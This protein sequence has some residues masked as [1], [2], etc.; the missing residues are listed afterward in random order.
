MSGGFRKARPG[1]EEKA[2]ATI[3]LGDS[4]TSICRFNPPAS[5]FTA[6]VDF[7]DGYITQP[8]VFSGPELLV[9]HFYKTPGVFVTKNIVTDNEGKTSTVNGIV[10]VLEP[11]VYSIKEKM[12]KLFDAEAIAIIGSSVYDK[13]AQA[14]SYID[15]KNY[16]EARNSM[17]ALLSQLETKIDTSSDAA[18]ILISQVQYII[19]SFSMASVSNN[20][21]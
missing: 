5:S 6:S 18:A 2:Q 7:G 21:P 8:F 1:E 19:K 17:Q 20:I 16:I 10:M 9:E 12:A 11:S 14:Q 13:L 15:N 4:F 3:Y